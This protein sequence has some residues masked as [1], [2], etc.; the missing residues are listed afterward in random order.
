MKT[1]TQN[2]IRALSLGAS[3][4]GSGGGGT[5]TFEPLMLSAL[6]AKQGPI[7]LIDSTKLKDND[8]VLPLA[9]MGAPLVSIEKLVNGSECDAIMANVTRLYGKRPTVLMNA[10]IGGS[11]AFTAP[12][13]AHRYNL[14]VLD[15]DLIGR[16]F[17]QLEMSSAHLAGI[18]P[19]PAF[20]GDSLGKSAI[21]EARSAQDIEQ[22]A[23]QI[24]IACGS[25]AAVGLYIMFGKEA[26][27]AVVWGSLSRACQL[28]QLVLDAQEKGIKG[29][30]YLATHAGARIIGTGTIKDNAQR[31]IE[32]FTIGSVTIKSPEKAMEPLTV[33]YKNEFLWVHT[34]TKTCAT[35]PDI[36]ALVDEETGIPLQT[37]SI[38]YGLRVAV[39]T[40]PAPDIWKTAAGLEL[41]GPEAFGLQD[42]PP[43]TSI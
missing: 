43:F 17:P 14:P 18:S 11:N 23:R 35:T 2:D 20:I 13:L 34:P 42:L 7:K 16:A 40:L 24:T 22:L 1:I 21:L 9:Y 33:W 31:T 26:Q 10:E 3:I 41:V 39:I 28:G 27:R 30:D 6:I 38:Q 12:L 15:A 19:S 32:G 36:I 5:P 8:L 37:D 4:L 25:S 29:P